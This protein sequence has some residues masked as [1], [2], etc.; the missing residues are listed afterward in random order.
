MKKI[1]KKGIIRKIIGTLLAMCLLVISYQPIHVNAEQYSGVPLSYEN[2]TWTRGLNNINYVVGDYLYGVY[3]Y[4]GDGTGTVYNDSN[5]VLRGSAY[6]T[7]TGRIV[8]I[9]GATMYVCSNYTNHDRDKQENDLCPICDPEY[10]LVTE[11][12]FNITSATLKMG[13]T[14]T[15]TIIA[16]VSP[17]DAVIKDISWTSN[18]EAVATVVGGVVTAVS[19]GTANI[20]ATSTDG[21]NISATCRVTVQ[22]AHNHIKGTYHAATTPTCNSAGNIEYWECTGDCGKTLDSSANEIA[23]VSIAIDSTAHDWG[24]TTS[25][26]HDGTNHWEVCSRNSAHT[27]NSASHSGGTATCTNQAICETC[28]ASYGSTDSSNH[29]F[30]TTWSKD[31]TNHWKAATCSHTSLKAEEAPHTLGSWVNGVK[32]CVCG[33][34]ESCTHGGATTGTCSTCGKSLDAPTPDSTPVPDN[35]NDDSSSNNEPVVPTRTYD[36]IENTNNNNASETW[37]KPYLVD[38]KG[39]HG[40]LGNHFNATQPHNADSKSVSGWNLIKQDIVAMDETK[41]ATNGYAINMN[42]ATR[43]DNETLAILNSKKVKTATLKMENNATMIVPTNLKTMSEE[44]INAKG[45]K[46]N[47]YLDI[48]CNTTNDVKKKIIDTQFIPTD[49]IKAAK[50]NDDSRM[51][52]VKTNNT[53]Y[54]KLTYLRLAQMDMNKKKISVFLYSPASRKLIPYMTGEYINGVIDIPVLAANF[55][56][57]VVEE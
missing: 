7:I 47:F 55:S 42:G 56:A 45:E 44:V 9:D 15:V 38:E 12:S 18:N 51:V 35:S 46:V 41:I 21:G 54:E 24:T 31:S 32:S 50:G 40:N 52:V 4:Y 23:D 25:Y 14:E 39:S 30:A 16:T 17:S 13:E 36:S 37:N 3:H 27:R 53:D 6:Q 8:K 48:T 10:K 49:I 26:G 11:I 34:S 1:F 29:S 22:S 28:G 57:L 43:V 2:G 19:A 20:K 33:Y 5:Q